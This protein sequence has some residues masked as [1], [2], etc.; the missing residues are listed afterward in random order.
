MATKILN[1]TVQKDVGRRRKF[2]SRTF[3]LWAQLF[4]FGIILWI[5]FEFVRFV[6]FMD[7]GGKTGPVPI[8]PPGVEGF[9][10]ISGLISLRDWFISGHVNSIHPASLIILLVV[11]VTAFLFKKGF[12]GWVCPVGFI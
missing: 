1:N 7:L 2:S 11:I 3:R 4:A 6:S 9:L 12:C 8:R 10:P 5:G